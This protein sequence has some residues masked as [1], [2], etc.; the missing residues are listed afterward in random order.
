MKIKYLLMGLILI[1]CTCQ[2]FCQQAR[3]ITGRLVTEGNEP[4]I[5]AN[6][7]TLKSIGIKSQSNA[8]GYFSLPYNGHADTLLI[9]H[10]GYVSM[11][12]PITA[13][14]TFPL[15]IQLNKTTNMLEEVVVNTGYQQ[16]PKERATGSF[17]Q[18]T[19]SVLNQQVSSDIMGR[20]PAIAN[21]LSEGLKTS[22]GSYSSRG[23]ILIRGLS[24]INGPSAPLI[25]LDN[26]PYEGDIRNINP[27]DV[28]SIT[29]LKDAAAASIWGA[30]AGNGVIV[31]TT[32]NGRFHQK[33]K[34]ELNTNI[35]FTE[36]PDLFYAQSISSGDL[37]NLE[38]FL[39]RKGYRFSDTLSTS[40]PPFSPAYEL[41]FKQRNGTLNSTETINQLN[42]LRNH[43]VRNDFNKYVYTPAV[44]QQYAINIRGGS[45]NIA[46]LLSGGFDKNLNV[47]SAG[48]NRVSLRSESDIKLTRRLQLKASLYF[49][50]SKSIS[51]KEGYGDVRTIKGGIP[52]YSQ[53]I[54]MNGVP[55]PLAKDYRQ[56]YLDAASGGNL[57]DWNYYPFNDYKHN[58][59]TSDVQDLTGNLSL[60]YLI[61]KGL[62]AEVKY[63]YERQIIS[64][65]NLRDE[66]SYYV[67]NLVNTFYQPNAPVH[68]PVPVGGILD[69]SNNSLTS[70][71]VR[72][73][74]NFNKNW[75]NNEIVAIAGAE[76]KQLLS[77]GSS[78][79]IYGYNDDILTKVPVDM[80]GSYKSYVTGSS[81]YIP[82]NSGL[83]EDINR[84]VSFFANAAYTYQQKYTVSLSARRDASNIFGVN[85]N[86]KW[87]PLWSAGASWLLS[88]ERFYHSAPIPY[89][90]VRA[91]YG[92]SGNIDPSL[93]AVTT[94]SYNGTSPYTLTPF[95][96]VDKFYNPDLKW[97][98]NRQIN[99]GVD[100]ASKNS[101][102]AGSIDYY[103]KKGIDLYGPSPLDQT[104]GLGV[105]YI[106]KNAADM[107]ARGMD[108][109]IHSLNINKKVR[110]T[111]DLNLS[112]YHDKVTSY[113]L[114]STQGSSFIG[115]GI[116][117]SGL[118]GKPVN[119]V[120]SYKWAGLDPL[121]GDPQGYIDG[122]VSK[123]YS[124]ITGSGTSI[125]DLVYSGPGLPATYG[126]LGN[127]FGY[128]GLS[129][130]VRLTYKLGYY[131]R[132][133]SINYNSL[134]IS[135]NG[136]ADYAKRWQKP[137]DE[138]FTNVPSMIYPAMGTRDEFYN[139]SEV[140][141][142]KGDYIRLQY[143]TMSYDISKLKFKRLPFENIRA[144]INLNDLG[145]IW[146]ANKEGLDPDYSITS[147]PP[148]K[149][150][151][152]G[153][154]INF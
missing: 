147:I 54:D 17:S 68:F 151:A 21:G 22:Q 7:A 96:A 8:D 60:S 11:S 39:F 75:Q 123:D 128:K 142:L 71:N 25:V 59:N 136:T 64:G 114:S 24:T 79:R 121:T 99:I 86:D 81:M 85:I 3:Y 143:I 92:V 57:L 12:I 32:K 113:Y 76:I 154:Q 135:L 97:E 105:G 107:L 129:I 127:T 141:V 62:S 69:L 55:I 145:I 112:I 2:A 43:D 14:T 33:I 63:Q 1:V 53:L 152:L 49:T 153:M 37:V 61:A 30:R 9:T 83:D 95:A 34:V 56:L 6:I 58:H 117:I 13:S 140:L 82:D 46:W 23:K 88:G 125:A 31:I 48:Y 5:N 19:N 27:N 118:V 66:Q 120:L 122:K 144:F 134:F 133:Q 139:N 148:S 29:L 115:N 36:K 98:K 80:V 94:M 51:G 67:R 87:N 110:W 40:H 41:L 73:Q 149:N 150:I 18:I 44:A 77:D 130:T 106:T 45:D 10:V 70:N 93:T 47:L 137:G 78:Y 102:I 126:S 132:K 65:K 26:F 116:E 111:S 101:R 28:E 146:R 119:S 89:L 124:S 50:E 104:T 52:V 138:T 42:T 103:I 35:K 100:F 90:R 108:I 4:V 20:L 84:F 72:G 38:E 74:L 16:L 109:E 131:F 91:T 15:Q